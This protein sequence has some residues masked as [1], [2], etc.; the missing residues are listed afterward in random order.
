MG[1]VFPD[2]PDFAVSIQ[3]PWAWLIVNGHKDIENRDWRTRFRGPVAIHAGKK[4]DYDCAVA[5][6]QCSHPVTGDILDIDTFLEAGKGTGGVVG[7]AEIVD[8]QGAD[9][10]QTR[11]N[12]W[13]V[14]KYGFV[15]RNARTVPFI[16]C[17]GALGFFDW[18]KKLSLVGDA[19]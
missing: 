13:F 4:V 19:L 6:Q 9:D 5:I 8:C 3:Q 12:P 16:P 18:R 10:W 15:I 7:V 11:D 17:K 14:G 2:V 1:K